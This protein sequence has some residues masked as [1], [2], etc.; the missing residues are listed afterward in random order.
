METSITLKSIDEL[1][2]EKF[3]IPAYQRGYRWGERQVKELLNDLKEFT[4]KEKQKAEFYCLQPLVITQNKGKEWE[5]IDGQQRITTTFLILNFL[6][7]RYTEERQK[8]LYTINYQ[9]RKKS[10]DFL[11]NPDP[12]KQNENIDFYHIYNAYEVIREWFKDRESLENDFESTLLNRTK[13]I[14]YEVQ[15]NDDSDAIDIFTRINIGKIPLT[16]GELIKALFLNRSN[17]RTLTDDNIR[18]KQLQIAQ[19]WD[20]IESTLQEDSFWYF[21]H[22]DKTN[23]S[24]RIELIFNLLVKKSERSSDH[25]D[26]Y[27]TFIKYKESFDEEKSIDNSWKEI[28]D[29]F[30]TFD[31]WYHDN[32]L[33]HLIGFLIAG[34]DSLLN[35]IKNKQNK[36]KTE[37]KTYLKSTIKSRIKTDNSEVEGV[38]YGDKRIK[39]LLLLF[40]V[41]TI[42]SN[43]LSDMRFPFDKFKIENWDI[44]HIRALAD[45]KPPRVEDQ[46]R[47]LRTLYNNLID[48]Q[49]VTKYLSNL[50]SETRILLDKEQW[51]KDDK[52]FDE[53]YRKWLKHFEE[54][55]N[56]EW[57]NSIGNLTLL[58]QETNRSY[59][60]A[61]FSIKRNVIIEKDKTVTFV[62]VCTKNVFLKY[63]SQSIGNMQYWS[64]D[65]SNSYIGNIKDTLKEYLTQD[66]DE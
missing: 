36:R 19:E 62:P 65:D 2:K 1:R 48:G 40:N 20:R 53:L 14:W 59:K 46:K 24:T 45:N 60:N 63:Y 29:Y 58:D 8:Q 41:V 52:Q 39:A 49:K 11:R 22:D 47:W 57:I 31:E 30:L 27:F 23:Y 28:K 26:P 50:L 3:I 37:F 10:L 66:T 56:P 43:H 54:E 64:E 34:R 18:L 32:E 21:I 16:N 13:F 51:E 7:Q 42:I 33:Y 38:E 61:V 4:E 25:D 44:E 9:T 55:D 15:I 17:F 6:N 5:V 12:T 35:I